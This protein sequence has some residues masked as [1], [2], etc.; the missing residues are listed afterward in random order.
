[1]GRILKKLRKIIASHSLNSYYYESVTY[2]IFLLR[3]ED[4]NCNHPRMWFTILKVF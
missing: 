4:K 2:F 3:I 1:M